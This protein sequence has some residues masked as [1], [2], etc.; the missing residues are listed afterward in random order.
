MWQ[1]V[2]A[3]IPEEPD[4]RGLTTVSLQPSASLEADWAG[5]LCHPACTPSHTTCS[6]PPPPP[7]VSIPENKAWPCSTVS[8][9]SGGLGNTWS[10]LHFMKA[11][12]THDTLSEWGDLWGCVV[13]MVSVRLVSS[14]LSLRQM[15]DKSSL[16]GLAQ[17][18]GKAGQGRPGPT[19][20]ASLGEAA[21]GKPL[22]T[23]SEQPINLGDLREAGSLGAEVSQACWE[24]TAAPCPSPSPRAGAP[25]AAP[26]P[27]QQAMLRRLGQQMSE[28]QLSPPRCPGPVQQA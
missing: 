13:L 15:G 12:A 22:R 1:E 23:C 17:Q 24:R 25:A 5:L 10:G 27:A 8:D 19:T 2:A 14:S 16:A 6:P 28:R 3:R 20:Q 21:A 9:L 7:Q 26:G 18:E 4:L 11:A